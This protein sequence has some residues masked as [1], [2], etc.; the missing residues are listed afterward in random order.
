MTKG[1]SPVALGKQP[2]RCELVSPDN[3]AFLKYD[4]YFIR[5]KAFSYR[6]VVSNI[7]RLL[8]ETLRSI[9]NHFIFF[10]PTRLFFSPKAMNFS[11]TNKYLNT[12]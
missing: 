6:K 8:K 5:Q 9:W 12:S 4:S 2:C 10:T 3:A 7:V 11:L 1:K